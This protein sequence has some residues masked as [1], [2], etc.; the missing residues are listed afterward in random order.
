MRTLLVSTPAMVVFAAQ[1]VLAQ[2]PC[3][4]APDINPQRTDD[5]QPG[6]SKSPAMCPFPFGHGLT[7]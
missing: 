3:N 5:G 4:I 1:D 2:D 7:Y 6:G